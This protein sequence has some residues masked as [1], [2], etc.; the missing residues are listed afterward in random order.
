MLRPDDDL[1]RYE[2]DARS[3][4]GAAAAVVRPADVDG[5]R[6]VLAWARRHRVRLV[7]QGA[8]SGLV[9]AGVPD[10]TG[11]MV[12]LSLER[13]THPLTVD[14]VD[15]VAHVGAGV[16]LSQLNDA[17]AAHGLF[18]PIDLGSDPSLGGMVATNTG[19]ARLL[20][21]GDVRHNL[22]A[23]E[24]ILADDEGT[25]LTCGRGLRKDNTGL[26][27]K[28]LFVGTG[29]ELGVVTGVTVQLHALPRARAAALVALPGDDASVRLLEQ[30][31]REVPAELT[32]YEL[33]SAEAFSRTLEHTATPCP[34]ADGVPPQTALVELTAMDADRDLATDLATVLAGADGVLDARFGPPEHWWALRHRVTESVKAF[35]TV[36]A[37]D[38][39]VRRP[40]VP[41]LRARTLAL[42]AE[43]APGAR[44][45]DFGHVGDGG[46]HLNLLFPTG[47]AAPTGDALADLR[48]AVYDLVDGLGGSFSA[49]HGV[50][51]RNVAFAE[52][53]LGPAPGAVLAALKARFDPD[54]LLGTLTPTVE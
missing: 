20:R 38:V 25:V 13:L 31:E 41:E 36:V 32:A 12:V 7:P 27:L 3:G 22:L 23:I 26:D 37:F 10:A 11:T 17:A 43:R 6:A 40:L 50:G 8:N 18:F 28:Q 53:Y 34:F 39:S 15:R 5:V 49:E 9:S 47:V 4:R 45:V 48:T 21:Y 30:L 33:I 54:G 51:P 24:V 1:A 44:L 35:G 14:P 29:G 52:R 16:R 19:G 42:L 46:V 2:L